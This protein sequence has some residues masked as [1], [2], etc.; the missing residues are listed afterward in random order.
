MIEIEQEVVSIRERNQRVERDKA[1]EG[2]LTRRACVVFITY[3]AAYALLLL[4]DASRP[5]LGAFVPCLGY[6]LSTLS[7][8][9][10][11]TYWER[12]NTK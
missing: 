8:P 11:R 9:F 1:W 6:I 5:A 7:L 4:I 10:V 12:W 2:S 3:G